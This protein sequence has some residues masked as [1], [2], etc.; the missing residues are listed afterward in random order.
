VRW[1]LIGVLGVIAYLVSMFIGFTRQLWVRPLLLEAPGT[2]LSLFFDDFAKTA[3][4]Q[5]AGSLARLWTV[6]LVFDRIPDEIPY[7]WGA[8]FLFVLNPITRRLGLGE[9]SSLGYKL[10]EVSVPINPANL[11][12]GLNPSLVG[13]VRANFPWPL[14]LLVLAVAGYTIRRLHEGLLA[15]SRGAPGVAL[16]GLV[17]SALSAAVISSIGNDLIYIVT[18]IG[19]AWIA[20]LWLEFRG[21]PRRQSA[22]LPLAVGHIREA[23]MASSPANH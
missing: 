8:S 13:E 14:A 16:Y 20:I 6:M 19:P 3:Y 21:R 18:S 15:P 23:P 10:W 5:L 7:Q 17:I 12:V 2:V 1:G 4:D 11:L 9:I 22:K